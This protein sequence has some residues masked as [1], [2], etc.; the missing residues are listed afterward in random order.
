MRYRQ[1]AE[2]DRRF[3]SETELPSAVAFAR[4]LPFYDPKSG[5]AGSEEGVNVAVLQW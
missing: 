4:P 3:N 5:Y 2:E 1:R